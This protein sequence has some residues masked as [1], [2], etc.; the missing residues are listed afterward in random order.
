MKSFN[1]ENITPTGSRNFGCLVS[2][3]MTVTKIKHSLAPYS[4]KWEK[5]VRNKVEVHLQEG[6]SRQ[7]TVM[8]V[9]SDWQEKLLTVRRGKPRNIS[10]EE[11]HND[12]CLQ[13]ESSDIEPGGSLVDSAMD[14][15][16]RNNLI[17]RGL[18]SFYSE[19]NQCTW[20]CRSYRVSWYQ[21]WQPNR[22]WKLRR[23]WWSFQEFHTR[24]YAKPETLS[25][26]CRRDIRDPIL[27]AFPCE[28]RSPSCVH[29]FHCSKNMALATVKFQKN[30]QFGH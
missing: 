14:T 10:D 2:G 8:S 4:P 26:W 15:D 5:D 27:K 23:E 30:S 6:I 24:K 18:L 7:K 11:D 20:S 29:R 13:Q 16:N 17:L 1:G 19:P 12:T 9:K 22:R 25:W 3:K 21:H 28:N